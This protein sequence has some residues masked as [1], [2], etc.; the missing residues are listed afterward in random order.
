MAL[1]VPGRDFV[2]IDDDVVED[3]NLGTTPYFTFHVGVPKVVALAELLY[4]RAECRALPMAETLER[5]QQILRIAPD[6]VVDTFDNAY[7]RALT[8]NLFVPTVHAGVSEDRA[9]AVLW[10]LGYVVPQGLPRGQNPVCTHDLGRPIL[11]TVALCAANVIERFLA[12][13]AQLN[14]F[15]RDEM[16][17]MFTSA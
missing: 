7:A 11:R 8:H 1:A 12:D 13:G 5:K 3:V 15:L 4:R 10:D 6:L 2:L 14:C 17:I 9:G 16:H